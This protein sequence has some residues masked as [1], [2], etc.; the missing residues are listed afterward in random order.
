MGAFAELRDPQKY[1][2]I[3][4]LVTNFF[5][6]KIRIRP[7]TGRIPFLADRSDRETFVLDPEIVV[8]SVPG[9]VKLDQFLAQNR[10][11]RNMPW[12]SFFHIFASFSRF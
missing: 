8:K 4:C 12:T 6:D 11:L 1:A 3:F 2:V 5:A 7:E 10:A 9:D